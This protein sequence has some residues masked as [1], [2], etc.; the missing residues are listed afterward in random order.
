[1]LVTVVLAMDEASD[2]WI[3]E[4]WEELDENA[5]EHFAE[6]SLDMIRRMLEPKR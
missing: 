4:H 6:S 5:V 2:R 3:Y 1:M